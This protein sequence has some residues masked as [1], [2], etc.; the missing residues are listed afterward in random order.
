MASLEAEKA[1]DSWGGVYLWE[2]LQNF[3]CGPNFLRSIQMLYRAP[4]ARLCTNNW[5]SD[6]FRLYSGICQG[7]PLFP[8]PFALALEPLADLFRETPSGQRV[9][10]V[11]LKEKLSLYADNALLYLNNAS[12]SLV[13]ALEISDEFGQIGFV[14]FRWPGICPS[15]PH[16]IAMGD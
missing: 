7:C 2:V 5:I 12:P 1:F 16:T 14:P 15:K 8:G 3:G 11:R 13:A 4:R 10:I 9:R 6:P